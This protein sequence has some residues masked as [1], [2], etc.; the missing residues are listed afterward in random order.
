MN[1]NK[2][3]LSYCKINN[4]EI[5]PNQLDTIEELNL[6]YNQNF[7]KSLLKKIFT[8]QN[9]KTGF[10][11]QG[12]VGVGKTMILNFFYNNFDKTKQ[13]FHFNEFMISFHDFVFKNK[14]NTQENIIDKFVKKLKSKSKLIYFDE[15]QV[16]NIVDAMILGSLFKKIFNENIKVL[17]SS[18][19]KINDLY[20]DGLQRDQFLPF[21]R[22]MKERSNQSK[23]IIQDDYRKSVKNR[24]ERYFYPLNESTNFK[25]NKFFRKITKNLINKEMI[26]SIKGRK[27]TIKNYFDGITRFDFK[28]LCS[29]NIGAEDYIKIAK[30]CNFIVIENIPIF[31]SDN[32]NQQ[33]RFITLIDILYEKNIPLMIT[34]QLQLDLLSSSEDLKKIFKRTISRLYELTSIK[35]TKV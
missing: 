8:K 20:K 28:E 13:R 11:L 19:T 10:Y 9:Y 18:N 34:S 4:L 24:N 23:L 30:V 31:K 16:T 32:S 2:L 12:D 35:Y 17:F 6:F 5:N 22:I 29:K 15:F 21:I 25:L 14:E 3:F 1:L 7:N 33:Q 27:L 26:L